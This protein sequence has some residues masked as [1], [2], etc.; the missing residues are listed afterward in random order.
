M[1]SGGSAPDTSRPDLVD[2]SDVAA[3]LRTALRHGGGW[4]EVFVERRVT[5]TIRLAGGGVGEVRSDLDTGA[6]VRV[7]TAGR[8]GYAHTNV[9]TRRALT[10]AA[11]AA[12]NASAAAANA[13][14]HDAS[15][16]GDTAPAALEPI[17]PID[18]T[19]RVVRRVQ[20]AL[21]APA[22]VA[23]RDKVEVMRRADEAARA[24]G[25]AIR[26]VTATHVDVT[27]AVLIASTD[28][29]VVRDDRVRTRLTCQVTAR[30]DGAL[31]TGF[32]G[33]GVGGGWEF[34]DG[35][36]AED[37]GRRAAERALRGLDGR[38]APGGRLPVVLG[39]S[40]GGLLLHEACGHGLEADGLVRRSSV[41]ARSLGSRVAGP[42]VTAVDDPSLDSGFGSYA[43][44]D[45][46]TDSART[47]LIDRGVQ[48]GALHDRAN[49]GSASAGFS[50]NGRRESFAHPPL[51]RMSNTFILPGSSS[52]AALLGSVRHG[53]YV[54]RLRGGDVN[55]ATGDFA[56]TAGES[57]LVEN[58]ELVQP[59]LSLTLLGSTPSALTSV[60]GV[61]D[62]L[63]LTQALCG[64]EGQWVPV[65]Y[66]SPT[67]LLGGLTV[68]GGGDG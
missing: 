7:V 21:R 39:P 14:A 68:T 43:I 35:R 27:Q 16:R 36:R 10:D 22:D 31:A 62:D 67:L 11:E 54:V 3:A 41:Y 60:E 5:E 48:T 52:S 37:V 51:P 55:I 56:F 23:A 34:Y 26:D 25:G 47:V 57:F 28:G 9:L 8:A 12:A 18:L 63:S 65:S 40:G 4:A 46:G 49:R 66:G 64:K 44:D 13:V 30:R 33:P 6:G 1:S 53:I 58:G 24:R 59:L 32:D 61:A 50:A 29:F 20:R 38:E 42:L 15:D 19:D 17:R 2:E 45:E